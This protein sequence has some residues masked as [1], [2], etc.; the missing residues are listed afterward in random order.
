VAGV[1]ITAWGYPAAFALTALF[2]VVAIGLVPVR[3]EHELA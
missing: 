3:H 2:P 1:V